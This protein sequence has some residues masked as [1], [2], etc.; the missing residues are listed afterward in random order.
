MLSFIVIPLLALAAAG[1]KADDR[2]Q[3]CAGCH[4]VAVAGFAGNVHARLKAFETPDGETGCVTCHGDPTTHLDSGEAADMRGFGADIEADSAACLTCHA[5]LGASEWHASAHAPEAGCTSCHT[6]HEETLPTSTCASCPAAV[7]ALFRAPSHHPVPEG[8]M[9]C[10]SCRTVHAANSGALRTSMRGNDLCYT[11]H[12]AQEGPFIFQ[13]DPVEE[14]CTIC[15]QPHG[16]VANNLLVA[17]E[18]F[19]C[20]QCHE[21]HF[22]TGFRAV[23]GSG[24]VTVGGKPYPNVNGAYGNQLAFGTK[25]TQCH[26]RVH[27]SDLPS[28]ST[29]GQGA[30]RTR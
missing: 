10:A 27:G 24:T 11:G 9:T 18:P 3:D 26:I 5:T 23:A 16:A 19:L 1:E 28:N 20:L 4:D 14:D 21:L 15:H 6:I 25:C 13:H 2:W 17:N 12:Q 30:N 22:H 29:P 8:A 7:Q